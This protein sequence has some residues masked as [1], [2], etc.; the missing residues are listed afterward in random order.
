[1]TPVAQNLTIESIGTDTINISYSGIYGDISVKRWFG[2]PGTAYEIYNTAWRQPFTPDEFPETGNMT[3]GPEIPLLNN[4]H[5]YVEAAAGE[6]VDD[7][8]IQSDSVLYEGASIN[9]IGYTDNNNRTKDYTVDI[10]EADSNLHSIEYTLDDIDS[11]APRWK[12]LMSP[13]SGGNGQ[14]IISNI[15]SPFKPDVSGSI[16][17]TVRAKLEREILTYYSEPVSISCTDPL[18]L[19]MAADVWTARYTTVYGDMTLQYAMTHDGSWNDT[20][21][22]KTLGSYPESD[23]GTP[24]SSGYATPGLPTVG[25]FYRLRSLDSSGAPLYSNVVHYPYSAPVIEETD[26]LIISWADT[27]TVQWTYTVYKDDGSDDIASQG[28]TAS[29]SIDL[30]SLGLEV[31]EYYVTVRNIGELIESNIVYFSLTP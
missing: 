12:S 10:A 22:I 18:Q 28:D 24:Y 25:Y 4:Y 20:S 11:A 3:L 13:N 5:Y 27:G 2:S 1:M 16:T 14:I 6:S 21:D 19:T 17:I 9:I 15:T 23:N 29:T 26:S 31:G 7:G 30:T 8:L